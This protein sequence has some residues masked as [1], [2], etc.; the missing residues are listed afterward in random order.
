MTDDDKQKFPLGLKT[1]AEPQNGARVPLRTRLRN[2]FLTGLIVAAPIAITLYFT[3]IVVTWVD[4][5]VKPLVPTAY[6]PDN[7]VPFPIPGV[8][9]IIAVI[10]LTV[11]GAFTANLFGRTIVS[12]GDMML[13]RMPIVRNIYRALKQIA[14]TILSQSQ[15]S[16]QNAALIEYPRKGLWSVVFISTKTRGEI[17]DKVLPGTEMVSVFLP[18]TP[19]P[20]SGYLLFVPRKDVQILDMSVED[21]AKLII[22]AGLVVPAY[23]KKEL[24]R[25]DGAARATKPP[26]KKKQAAKRRAAPRKR[27]AQTDAPKQPRT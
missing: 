23:R 15:G 26:A 3:W 2:Y 10:G 22:S 11:L 27:T 5:W 4:A 18:T 21:A 7:Y 19:N 14:E 20:T 1:L 16:F 25:G 6:N 13:N 9:L 8:G 12:W 17:D 24:V